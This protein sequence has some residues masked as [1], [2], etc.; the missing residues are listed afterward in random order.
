MRQVSLDTL[1]N[2]IQVTIKKSSD[3]VLSGNLLNITAGILK[4]VKR[5]GENY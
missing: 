4:K 5:F 3:Y 1:P 2:M